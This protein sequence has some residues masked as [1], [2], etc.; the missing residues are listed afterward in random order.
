VIPTVRR[1]HEPGPRQATPVPEHWLIGNVILSA[2]QVW[3]I[4]ACPRCR[5]DLRRY[6]Q[7]AVCTNTRCAYSTAPFPIVDSTP[8][9]VDF[10]Q[11][12]LDRDR[13]ETSR[14]RSPIS[15]RRM[16]TP[17]RLLRSALFGKNSVASG[18]ERRFLELLRD[19]RERPVCVIVGG[20]TPGSGMSLLYEAPFVEVLGLD[21]Y[22]SPLVT[23]VGD[24]HQMP[25]KSGSVDGVWIQAVLE[26][27][28]NPWQVVSEIH[29]V[30]GRGGLVY[31]ETPF[32]QQVHEGPYDFTRFTHSGHR[33]L[34][35]NF[36]ELSSGIVAG[37]GTQMLWAV[38]YFLR[39]LLRSEMAGKVAKV[40]ASPLRL[41]DRVCGETFQF[42]SASAFFFLGRRSDSSL[43]IGAMRDY[44]RGPD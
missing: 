40:V 41:F 15:R 11:S 42:Q 35:K 36:E 30:L 5:E 33:W 1:Y 21:I 17:V 25:I 2:D 12:I 44:Y 32:M 4:L 7:G 10:E 23:I 38:E 43:P 8:V 20:A 16:R 31:A 29:R 28:L 3:S 19:H 37:V 26:H 13:A 39:A 9:L 27:V 24:A 18:N 14:W 22:R 6:A 34:F